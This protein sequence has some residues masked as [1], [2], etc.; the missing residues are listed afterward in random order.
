VIENLRQI[1]ASTEDP[2]Q[3]P[4]ERPE[5]AR[6]CLVVMGVFTFMA[7]VQ[8]SSASEQIGWACAVAATAAAITAYVARVSSRTFLAANLL[9]LICFV[10][11]CAVVV[12][13][14]STAVAA[15]FFTS[16]VPVVA[17]Q[18]VGIRAAFGWFLTC[19]LLLAGVALQWFTGI[20]DPIELGPTATGASSIR[21]A[22]IFL[23]FT[24]MIL[25]SSDI[26]RKAAQRR[27]KLVDDERKRLD[28]ALAE[29]SARYRALVENSRDVIIEIDQPGNVTYASQ[30]RAE[31]LGVTNLVGSTLSDRIW[32][33]DREEQSAL[34]AQMFTGDEMLSSVP[35]RYVG[36][37][38]VWRWIETT[39]RRYDSLDGNHRVVIR[40]RDVTAEL[41][42][43]RKLQQTQKL[44]AVG[45]LAAGVAHDFNNLL[46]VI[47]GY[48][49]DITQATNSPADAANEILRN[50]KR[51]A[52]LTRQLLA[53]SRESA[54]TPRVI[55]L[56]DI[57]K[58]VSGMLKRLIGEQ[59]LVQLDLADDLPNVEA[60]PQLL[61]QAIINLVVNARDA[62][63]T[64]AIVKIR[65]GLVADG[66]AVFV[67]VADSGTGMSP[68]IAERAFDPFF[69]TK[70]IGS[71]TG[72]GL[73]M[74][75][76]AVEQ[77]G[78]RTKLET[79]EGEGTSVMIQLPS[80]ALPV[81]TSG[82]EAQEIEDASVGGTILV[83]ENED[84]IRKLVSVNLAAA[85][86]TVL[87]AE[88]GEAALAIANKLNHPIDLVVSDVIMPKMSGPTMVTHLRV[89]HPNA[90][91]LFISGHPKTHLDDIP[92]EKYDLLQKPFRGDELISRV[93]ALLT[94]A[95][96]F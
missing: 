71:G 55:N 89:I 44:Q 6:Y 20:V 64:G 27:E 85:G 93:R 13:T 91:V 90:K 61:E 92:S 79:T 83:V 46:T 59:T 17:L 75:H 7:L 45:Q 29:E 74:V 5:V 73:A 9:V 67:E 24:F 31:V 78:G 95:D 63:P 51:G 47:M 60:D 72:L 52:A 86:F 56:S 87:E 35:V 19:L 42:L 43:L 28:H 25:A 77:M 84:S 37:D 14:Q 48:A 34:F 12:T 88:D 8:F 15:L 69:T 32:P 49:D 82:H 80:T 38:D 96:G 40:L 2:G 33:S 16:L 53:F 70:D 62:S 18:V 54:Y 10:F 58:N 57:V 11:A 65:T 22:I 94:G 39:G 50:A 76:G 26:T 1:W 21:A 30:N 36:D 41:D 3:N 66:G 68:D 4:S 81:K 23:I